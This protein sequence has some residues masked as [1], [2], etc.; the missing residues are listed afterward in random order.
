[1]RERG[2]EEKGGGVV[3]INDNGEGIVHLFGGRRES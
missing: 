2:E 3:D 1:M